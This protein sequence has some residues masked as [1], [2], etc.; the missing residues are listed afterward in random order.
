MHVATDLQSSIV[1]GM[2]GRTYPVSRREGSAPSSPGRL[3]IYVGF[4]FEVDVVSPVVAAAKPEK[5]E[6][7]RMMNQNA[8]IYRTHCAAGRRGGICLVC[9]GVSTEQLACLPLSFE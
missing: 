3:V 9:A 7:R 4:G 2:D 8:A 5:K 6:T 1:I